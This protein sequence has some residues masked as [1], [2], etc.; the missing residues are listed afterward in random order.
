MS[1]VSGADIPSLFE[2]SCC[3]VLVVKGAG[4][5]DL[6]TDFLTCATEYAPAAS[7]ASTSSACS[8]LPILHFLPARFSSVA[9]KGE[10]FFPSSCSS[11]VIV[12]Y[13]S[14][15]NAW[16]SRSRSTTRRRATDC[17][18]PAESPLLILLLSSGDNL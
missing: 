10:Y 13:S 5:C 6:V 18:L 8:L 11:A 2:A 12:Q 15:L 16:I 14:G 7:A 1:M 3:S 4:A 17:T 9:L